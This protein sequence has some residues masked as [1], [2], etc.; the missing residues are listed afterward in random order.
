[1]NRSRPSL[2]TLACIALVI[3]LV[4]PVLDVVWKCRAGFETSEACVWG[5]SLFPLMG[6]ISLVIIA[7][8]TF[9]LLVFIRWLWQTRAGRSEPSSS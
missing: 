6:A 9:G 7:P 3:G 5:K 2:L 4:I 1:M 8:V